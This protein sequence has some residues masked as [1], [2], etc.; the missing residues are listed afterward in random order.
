MKAGFATLAE[1]SNALSKKGYDY[2]P[3]MFSHW[4]QG[5]RIPRNRILI[6]VFIE[7]FMEKGAITSIDEANELLESAGQGYL[8]KRE[9][10][11]FVENIF[12]APKLF[13]I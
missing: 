8:T 4:Q 5:K 6:I 7:L 1:V 9:Q 3:S 10:V 13:T 2:D 12:N 11:C